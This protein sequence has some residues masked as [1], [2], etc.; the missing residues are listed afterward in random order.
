MLIV[1]FPT[2]DPKIV[3][4]KTITTTTTAKKVAIGPTTVVEGD[5]K[6][7]E[8]LIVSVKADG[9]YYLNIGK[10]DKALPIKELQASVQKVIK[11]RPRTHVLVWGDKNVPYGE[12]V[13]LMS[14]LQTAGV[15]NVGLVTEAP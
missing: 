8:P 1:P 4:V 13:T 6:D 3:D 10:Q 15:P 11:A 14:H 5:S 9:T 12:V 7:E 2:S